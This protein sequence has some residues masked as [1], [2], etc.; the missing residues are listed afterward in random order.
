MDNHPLPYSKH[1][2]YALEPAGKVPRSVEA[3]LFCAY[4]LQLMKMGRLN[5]R[6]VLQRS[7]ENEN[8][9]HFGSRQIDKHVRSASKPPK[10]QSRKAAD[11]SLF[12]SCPAS[13][14]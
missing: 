6:E 14:V 5:G 4:L 8:T 1:V 3:P 9:R 2:H 7:T 12:P 11:L 13:S 10:K